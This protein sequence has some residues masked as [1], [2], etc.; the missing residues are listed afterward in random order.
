MLINLGLQKLK[1]INSTINQHITL[2]KFL[3]ILLKKS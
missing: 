1:N 2:L 3:L